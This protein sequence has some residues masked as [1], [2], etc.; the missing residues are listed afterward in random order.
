M[1]P[2]LRQNKSAKAGS[3]SRL[4][5]IIGNWRW[6]GFDRRIDVGAGEFAAHKEQRTAALSAMA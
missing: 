5:K 1:K 6:L 3:I 2:D 4:R